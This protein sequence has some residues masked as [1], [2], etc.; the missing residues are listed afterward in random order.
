MP[1][2]GTLNEQVIEATVSGPDGANRLF[3]CTG[4]AWTYIW[5]GDNQ[6]SV[7]TFTFLVGPELPRPQFYRAI[8]SA[9]VTSSGVNVMGTGGWGSVSIESVEAD[10]D[11]ESSRTQVRVE[12]NATTGP[13]IHPSV[14]RVSYNVTI[15]GEIPA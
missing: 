4:Q 5:L 9:S 11:D 8:A 3:T 2:T 12:F 13:G 6:Q 14:Q 1:A 7:P 15:L 10:W